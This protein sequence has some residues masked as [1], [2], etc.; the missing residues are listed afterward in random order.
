MRSSFETREAVYFDGQSATQH[1]VSIQATPAGLR[2]SL[3]GQQQL[4]QKDELYI[5][6][7]GD[8][9]A[10]V[11]QRN[12]EA[13]F[14]IL[15]TDIRAWQ[16]LGYPGSYKK[17]RRQALSLGLCLA[18]ACGTILGLLYMALTPFSFWVAKK[19]PYSIEQNL[20]Q[21][22]VLHFLEDDICRHEAAEAALNGYKNQLLEQVDPELKEIVQVTIVD[23]D[24]ANAFALP[25]GKIVFTKAALEAPEEQIRA[26]LAH[27]IAH[28][29]E[30]HVLG[31]YIKATLFSGLAALLAGDY[32]NGIVIDPASVAN[33]IEL[34]FS[35]DIEREADHIA[36]QYLDQVGW[37]HQPLAD[38]LAALTEDTEEDASSWLQFAST[39]PAT[40]ERTEYISSYKRQ[41]PIVKVG[42]KPWPEGELICPPAD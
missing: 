27:E 11:Q 9:H 17:S 31:G 7:L 23:W 39:H 18:V 34:G 24:M 6:D 3:N 25:G 30:R 8:G 10:V 2:W 1:T 15:D 21:S 28:V 13:Y 14:K 41:H 38:F 16:D 19:V 36:L 40:S 29:H 35:R 42:E 20:F 33:I 32:V 5:E 4:I 26:V 12:S 37:D 22:V